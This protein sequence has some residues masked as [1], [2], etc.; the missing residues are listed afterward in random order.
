MKSAKAILAILFVFSLS[1][2]SRF[3][4]VVHADVAPPPAPQLGG[5]EPFGYQET[6][7]QMVYERVEMELRPYLWSADD[8]SKARVNVTA[9]FTMHNRGNG[10]ESM[11]AIFPLESFTECDPE[12]VGVSNNY[13]YYFVNV[14]SFEVMINGKG[15]P[16]QNIVTEHPHAG[17]EQMTWAGFDVTFPVD[18]DVTIRVQYMMESMDMDLLQ[19][20]EYILETGAGW[21]GP[22]Q[23]GYVIVKFPYEA[24]PENVLSASTP[25]Y[26]FLHNEIFWSFENLEPTSEDNIQISIVSPATWQE[27]LSLRRDLEENPALPEKWLKLAQS[28]EY[29]ST[30]H[31]AFVRNDHYYQKVPA[32]YEQGIAANPN[33]ALLY[34]HY[35]QFVHNDCCFVWGEEISSLDQVRVLNLV[36]KALALDPNDP[37]ALQVLDFVRSQSPGLTFTP[38]AVIPPTATPL[39][40]ATPSITPSA[41]LTYMPEDMGMPVVVTVVHT[42]LVSAPTSTPRL[43]PAATGLP[44][45]MTVQDENQNRTTA[46]LMIFGALIF[47]IAGI[48][49]GTFWSKRAGK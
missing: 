26:Q 40:T 9:Y 38:P 33:S 47:F 18:E 34:S 24:T 16:V 27:I 22:I 6:N 17:C 32:I 45:K 20:I 4:H 25:G 42:E 49:A 44:T 14:S 35:A 10:P 1:T 12:G 8:F 28:Y 46:P 31:G 30:W 43:E 39:F 7:V 13:T 11:R 21:A 37:I 48:G 5:L 23:R 19:N 2:S 3:V 36:N 29:L 15:V 41:T